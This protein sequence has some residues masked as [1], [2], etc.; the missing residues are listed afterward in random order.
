M[1]LV[2]DSAAALGIT[3]L[4][5]TLIVLFVMNIVNMACILIRTKDI[6]YND[7]TEMIKKMRRSRLLKEKN[8]DTNEKLI[9]K[10]LKII[11]ANLNENTTPAEILALKASK[12][13]GVGLHQILA[14]KNLIMDF[15]V[16]KHQKID[17]SK[18]PIDTPIFVRDLEIQD[19]RPR[20]FC[21]FKNGTIYAHV[22]GR[23]SHTAKQE[24]TP[25]KYA[26]L[27]NL[28]DI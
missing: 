20:H 6:L 8:M 23:T 18:V 11:T 2:M 13:L 21:K 15:D 5:M 14:N 22:A 19:W 12:S 28:E 26:K 7:F 16:A 10:V 4:I 3:V 24:I 9:E 27:A 1:R 25:W 17:W